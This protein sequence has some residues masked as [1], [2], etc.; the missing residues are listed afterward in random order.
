[1]KVNTIIIGTQKSGTTSLYY[2][3]KQHPDIYF[4]EVKEITYFDND[5]FYE[6]G[7]N[8]FHS[9]FPNFKNQKIIATADVH[10]LP[11][12][13]APGRVF[14][15][16]PN[17]KI[18]VLLREPVDRAYS[19]FNYAKK[20][21]WENSEISFLKSLEKEEEI[22]NNKGLI[23]KN[24]LLYFWNGLYHHHLTNWF[25][26]FPKDSFFIFK[27]EELRNNGYIKIKELF[28]FLGISENQEINTSKEYNKAGNVK[29][30][31]IQ[32]YI[33]SKGSPSKKFIGSILPSK[34]K[35]FIRS[36]VFKKL[37]ELNKIDKENEPLQAQDR[38]KA[39]QY[40]RD[41]LLKLKEELSITF[42]D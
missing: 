40:F 22:R 28:Q 6:K 29:S 17:I 14:K 34:I 16:N 21:G 1:M 26:Y 15:Y 8:Y 31:F 18:I 20:N 11:S 7:I 42:N 38:V 4:S 27:D 24:D 36:K 10:L 5:K 25:K 2:Y 35:V 19:A 23:R 30:K 13:T 39:R 33:L 12:A 32:K 37:I 41:D 9:F 3:L